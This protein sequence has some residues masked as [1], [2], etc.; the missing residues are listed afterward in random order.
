MSATALLNIFSRVP[1]PI[2]GNARTGTIYL[3]QKAKVLPKLAPWAVPG[4]IGAVWFVWPAVTDGAKIMLGLIPDP[5]EVELAA[6]EAAD[7]AAAAASA[8]PKEEIQEAIVKAM[9]PS[10]EQLKL[11]AREERG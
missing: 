6:L 7:K 9:T 4:L 11:A 10:P 3:A 5:E 2:F 1:I 8:V